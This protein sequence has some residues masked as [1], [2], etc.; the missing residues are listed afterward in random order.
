M[1]RIG[2]PENTIH[3]PKAGAMETKMK[4]APTV[5]ALRDARKLGG[6]EVL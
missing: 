1:A 6:K 2:T 4:A 3:V 5:A